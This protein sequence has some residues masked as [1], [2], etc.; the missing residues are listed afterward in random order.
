MLRFLIGSSLLFVGMMIGL[1]GAITLIGLPLGLAVAAAG[2]ELLV[3]SKTN[4]S[5]TRGAG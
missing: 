3:G 1:S 5:S 2:L 4:R